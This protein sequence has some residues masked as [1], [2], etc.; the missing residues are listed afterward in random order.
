M[1][2]RTPTIALLLLAAAGACAETWFVWPESPSDGPGTNWATAFHALQDAVDAAADHDTVQVTNGVYATGGRVPG[3]GVLTN[4]LV[5]DKSVAL[6][7]VAGPELTV[8]E[9]QGPL[10]SGA[11]RC[12]YLGP[13]SSLSGFTLTNGY[14]TFSGD[15]VLDLYGGGAVCVGS[16]VLSNC[17]IAGNLAWEHGGGVY[18]GA[19]YDSL[20]V[21]N[22]AY[23]YGGGVFS[24]TV[25]NCTFVTNVAG[26]GAGAYDCT[27]RGSTFDRNSASSYGGGAA[28]SSLSGCTLTSNSAQYGGGLFECT[29]VSNCVIACNSASFGG[30]VHAC[31]VKNSLLIRN[32]GST[33]GAAS[34][35]T[36]E[37]CTIVGNTASG[38]GGGLYLSAASNSIVYYNTAGEDANWSDAAL[39]Y[40]CTTPDSGGTGNITGPPGILGLDNPCLVSNSPCVDTGLNA[41]WMATATD[42][43]GEARIDNGT[44]D[45]GA[46]EFVPAGMTSGLA[47]AISVDY[48]NAVVGFPLQFEAVIDGRASGYAWTWGDGQSNLAQCLVEHP[49]GA[50][51]DYDAEL[52]AW[53]NDGSVAATVTV[54]IVGGVTNYVALDGGHNSPFTTWPDAATNIQAAIDAHD[55]AG[56]V[57]LVTNGVYALG[58]AAV[59]GAMPNRVALTHAV[60]VTSVNGPEFTA[61]EGAGPLGSNAVR[62]AYVGAKA[63]LCGF[64]LTNGYTRTDGDT[65]RE[66]SGGG[67]WC[68]PDA[69]VSGCLITACSARQYGGGAYDGTLVDCFVRAN[70]AGSLGGGLYRC[71][72]QNLRIAGNSAAYGGGAYKGSL[73]N[74]LISENRA[75]ADGGGAGYAGLE[76][77]TVAGNSAGDEGG[78]VRG[79]TAE[80]CIVYYNT[81]FSG[82][83]WFE[84]DSMSHCCTVPLPAGSGHMTNAPGLLGFSN[85][86]IVSNSPCVNAGTNLSWM[87][88]AA[89]PDGDARILDG[90]VDI[91]CDEFNAGSDTGTLC[92][93]I[94][95][96]FTNAVLGFPLEFE[97]VIEGMASRYEWQWGDGE[98]AADRCVADHTYAAPGDYDA[99]LTAW[100]GDGSAAA[101]ARVHVL[102]AFT[103]YVAPSG[104]GVAPFLT[105]ADAATNIQDAI[106][107]NT[108]VGGVVLVT[109]AVYAAGGVA[110]Y[111]AAMNRIAITNPVRVCGLDGPGG[112]VIEG[113]GPVGTNAVR[114]A[115]V[116]DGAQLLGCTLTNGFTASSGDSTH[117]Q[118]GGGVW[119]APGAV[120]SNC[121]LAGNTANQRGGGAYGGTLLDCVVAGNTASSGG[122]AC[123]A[124]VETC[125]VTWNTSVNDGAGIAYSTG[126]QSVISHNTVT[127]SRDGGG[128]YEADVFDCTLY[129]NSAYKGGGAAGSFAS[130]SLFHWNVARYAGGGA[131]QSELH[132][133]TIADNTASNT[134]GGLSFRC[135]AAHCLIVSNTALLGA[136]CSDYTTNWNCTIAHNEASSQGGGV[137]NQAVVLNSVLYDNIAPSSSNWYSVASIEC[138]CTTPSY[139]GAGNTTA[140]PQFLDSPNGNFRLAQG[141]PC[142]DTGTN[143]VEHTF[144]LDGVGRPLDGDNDG[145]NGVDMG[146]YECVHAEA[147][148][149]GDTVKDV[150]ELAADTDPSDS[151]SVLAMTDVQVDAGDI[152]LAWQGGV[153]ATQWVQRCTN[154]ISNDWETIFTIEPPT[155]SVTNILDE[156]ATNSVLFYRIAVPE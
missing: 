47:V 95:T 59:Y 101:T 36:F 65:T 44:V 37:N 146:A 103:N 148:S 31:K 129:G 137:Y 90:I 105:W 63:Q 92:V 2:R 41:G 18:A 80:N 14:T 84:L 87:A 39:D 108:V 48:T 117:E 29:S 96:D 52:T 114:C 53:N 15:E 127:G 51:G 135:G 147:D 131:Y 8:I 43:D 62:G 116:A 132:Q 32:A 86:H 91:G 142:I 136:G 106:A 120:V 23:E 4:R 7:G 89:D 54:H 155:L 126:R 143:L 104:N 22:R 76:S 9:G 153:Q 130:H 121:M 94:R 6:E 71:V 55:T 50:A 107:A 28:K 70:T 67:V 125:T 154:L 73:R 25:E 138:S 49:Y 24:G 16:V 21:G 27:V 98:S 145:T 139:A 111:G 13:G 60:V 64:T 34:Y 74:C 45:I 133:C 140:A 102:S 77:C 38:T 61:I 151:N 152:R 68:D 79:G 12:V 99:V 11:A 42:I 78:G 113:Q 66:Q 56:G 81:A 141:S 122:G 150:H 3:G 57:V 115:Y 10:G 30:G 26:E 40:C 156:N 112:V 149:D 17:I 75:D 19:T 20:F 128:A 134:G 35:G 118:S 123:A 5:V 58:G 124:L 82:A 88:G 100:N 97:A 83:N 1:T 33:G 93:A 110:V 69:V 109:N 85:P 144:D 46:D 119:C 72:G